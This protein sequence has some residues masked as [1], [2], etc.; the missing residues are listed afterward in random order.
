MQGDKYSQWRIVRRDLWLKG[1]AKL[2]LGDS[3]DQGEHLSASGSS[4]N[5]LIDG[6]SSHHYKLGE[7]IPT[8][9]S[10]TPSAD[11]HTTWWDAT[12]LASSVSGSLPVTGVLIRRA[13]P[14][15]IQDGGVAQKPALEEVALS[16]FAGAGAL[17]QGLPAQADLELAMDASVMT[18]SKR[19]PSNPADFAGATASV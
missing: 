17:M 3:V 18:G 11:V 14:E 13:S 15:L 12:R 2:K 9:K 19:P 8:S 7:R 6:S 4:S 10:S 1:Q 16:V 5:S